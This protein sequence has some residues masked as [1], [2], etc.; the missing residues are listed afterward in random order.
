MHRARPTVLVLLTTA[1]V[2]AVAAVTGLVGNPPSLASP[3]V[4]APTP[5]ATEQAADVAPGL[6]D[7]PPPVE[8]AGDD[9][10]TEAGGGAATEAD[11]GVVDGTTVFDDVPAVTNLDPDLL[12]ALR[13]AADDAAGDG[14]TIYV[15]SGWRSAAYQDRLLR[16]AVV[17][18]GSAAEASRWVATAQTSA[19]VTGDAIDV[20]RTSATSWLAEH[21]ARFGL[22]QVYANEP[23]HYELRP[24]AV[25]HGCPATYADPTHDPR[26][27][28]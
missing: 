10:A 23:W 26:M 6:T 12:H 17:Q 1:A 25:D 5:V 4:V 15:N 28:R 3:P 8:G 22:C 19:H 20:G 11:G 2:G 18:Y 13:V 24:D 16:D 7:A 21:G 27:A 9:A 14:V